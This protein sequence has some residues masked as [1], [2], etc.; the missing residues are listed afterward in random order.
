MSSAEL[1]C[2]MPMTAAGP[3]LE[4]MKPILM[5][6]VAARHGAVAMEMAAATEAEMSARCLMTDMKVSSVTFGRLINVEL[7]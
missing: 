6:V 7:L 2:G 1:R 5:G 3:V 4:T